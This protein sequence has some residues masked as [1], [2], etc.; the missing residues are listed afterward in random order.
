[1]RGPKKQVAILPYS[2]RIPAMVPKRRSPA[3]REKKTRAEATG[4][5]RGEWKRRTDTGSE[6]IHRHRTRSRRGTRRRRRR[7]G[8]RTHRRDPDRSP[9]ARRAGRRPGVASQSASR[10]EPRRVK[11]RRPGDRLPGSHRGDRKA[12]IEARTTKAPGHKEEA[13]GVQS[14]SPVCHC[15]AGSAL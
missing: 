12:R 8:R 13:C 10:S 2:T 7:S 15:S 4:W 1:M 5:K 14:S 9:L 3:H 6:A 11:G